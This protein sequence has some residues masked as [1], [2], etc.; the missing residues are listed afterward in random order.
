[1]YRDIEQPEDKEEQTFQA[2]SHDVTVNK[3]PY[4]SSWSPTRALIHSSHCW[5]LRC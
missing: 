5:T 2:K 4:S 1:M 3:S